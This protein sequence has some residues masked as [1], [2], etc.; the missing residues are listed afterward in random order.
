MNAALHPDTHVMMQGELVPQLCINP[1]GNR[2]RPCRATYK[3]EIIW[4][5]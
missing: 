3:M 5:A 4:E 2:I 1:Y